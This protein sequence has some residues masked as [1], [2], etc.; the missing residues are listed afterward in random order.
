M[1]LEIGG[2]VVAR[3]YVSGFDLSVV[4]LGVALFLAVVSR[5]S[6][7]KS[8]SALCAALITVQ[9]LL[10]FNRAYWLGLAL[11]V[12]VVVVAIGRSAAA[13][14]WLGVFALGLTS[15]E[16][17]LWFSGGVP[18]PLRLAASRAASV[19]E[20]VE[21]RGSLQWRLEDNAGRLELARGS[22]LFGVGFVHDDAGVF[23]FGNEAR[24]LRTADSGLLSLATDLGLVG[25]IVVGLL[26][27]QGLRRSLR[28]LR[29]GAGGPD[30]ALLFGAAVY[31]VTSAVAAPAWPAFV[32]YEAIVP[33]ALTLGV[34]ESASA[35]AA[36]ERL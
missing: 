10:S 1:P 21:R 19:S 17:M 20:E 24:G 22:P 8:A 7:I 16:M 30:G 5:P 15:L 25:I 12:S 32:S 23:R 36:Q 14:R 18:G 3:S 35:A 13:L 11:A 33:L 9:I 31:L 4:G 6:L 27:L 34:V 28:R 2:V 29:A 26:W